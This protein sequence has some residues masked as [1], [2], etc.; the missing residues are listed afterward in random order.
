MRKILFTLLLFIN[1]NHAR[2]NGL[3]SEYKYNECEYYINY[4]EN[5]HGIPNNL[6]KAI[7]IIESGKFDKFSGKLMP[8]PWAIGNGG[9]ANYYNNKSEAVI[10]IEKLMKTGERNI[11]IGCMQINLLH[12]PSAFMNLIQALDP[13]HN[14]N[15]GAKFL[16]ELFIK[17]TNWHK[18]VAAYH[19]HNDIGFEYAN[20]VVNI[21]QKINKNP[22]IIS[23][24]R[25][26]LPAKIKQT[27]QKK[28]YSNQ[29]LLREKTKNDI[30]NSLI[31]R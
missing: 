10:A 9:I 22:E 11:D 23:K 12:H 2:S 14:I 26:V 24:N 29:K 21:W 4:Y 18:A 5:M 17:H 15:Y 30:Q 13:A 31:V 19:S 1:Y 25:I 16:K 20:K 27:N 3:L 6:L 8:W 7:S 28:N